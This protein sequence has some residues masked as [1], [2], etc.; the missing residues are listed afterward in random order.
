[1]QQGIQRGFRF[2]CHG[3]QR[4]AARATIE[5]QLI[6]GR[7]NRNGIDINKE[8]FHQIHILILNFTRRNQIAGQHRSR[9][10]VH[11]A[12]KGIGKYRNYADSA[13]SHDRQSLAVFAGVYI[14]FI[15]TQCNRLGNRSNVPVG[16][17]DGYDVFNLGKLGNR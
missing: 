10:I 9:K 5:S 14:Q 1:M 11:L 6:H 4:Q 8:A 2:F 15:P 7:F 17:F 12:G 3:G 16:F 13:Q